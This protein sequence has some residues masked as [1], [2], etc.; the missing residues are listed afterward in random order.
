MDS[1]AVTLAVPGA[2]VESA[3]M[4]GP[5]QLVVLGGGSIG[6][7]PL[8]EA[9]TVTIGRSRK[10]DVR[11]DDDS[12]SRLHAKLHTGERL[13]IE[14]LGSA[15]GTLVR[16]QKIAPSRRVDVHLGDVIQ[17]GSVSLLVQERT[18]TMR[19][20][21]LWSHDYFEARVEDECAR[22][23]RTASS[24][25]VIRIMT[26]GGALAAVVQHC[27]A[28]ILRPSDIISTYGPSEY[29]VLLCETPPDRADR[30]ARR[31]TQALEQEGVSS[32]IRT[33]AH[34]R[35]G[36]TAHAL[37]ARL[38]A[39]HPGSP[40][41]RKIVVEPV[42]RSL[43]EMV[44][45]IGASDLS[46]LLLGETGVGKEVFAE[47]VHQASGRSGSFIAINCAALSDNLSESEL[48]GHEKGAFTSAVSAKVGLLEAADGGTV[49]L[50]EVGE[51]QLSTQ[52]KLLRVIEDRQ[53][54]RVGEVK[55]RRI[56]VRFVAATNRDL[57]AE[58][59]RGAFR[60]DLYFRLNGV[61][62]VIPSLRER[63]SEIE[64]LAR[65]FAERASER[66]GVPAPEL[67]P[68][69]RQ[70]LQ[71]YSWPG[72][73]RELRNVIERAVVL[74]GPGPI[75]PEHLPTDRMRDTIVTR[76]RSAPVGIEGR[77]G[78]DEYERIVAALERAHGNQ[79]VAATLLN[80]SR[81]TL[82]N[83]MIEFGLPR[84]RKDRS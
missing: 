71:S 33:A 34:P 84:P 66:T 72:N 61:T 76:G 29:D 58:V 22:A 40:S 55:S 56:N 8:P 30:V 80:I 11:V 26:S 51:M 35:D 47:A 32:R 39:P 18:T 63:V 31:I 70:L 17:V 77:R 46:I 78:P 68:A 64:P 14:D 24:F 38:A 6:S 69:T 5:L 16:G 50:D 27:L 59:E 12:I 48:F 45:R 44:E 42:M 83:R 82:I 10:C 53:I 2:T 49:L 60:R 65:S 20:R 41:D 52:A 43:Y 21:R 7:H 73:I 74:C 23:E 3:L 36:R 57:E 54:R 79:T 75:L 4:S 62:L 9:G 37:I 28:D 15:N 13:T 19:P 1:T 67:D 25:V 81:R